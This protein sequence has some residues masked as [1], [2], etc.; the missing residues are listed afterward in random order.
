MDVVRATRPDPAGYLIDARLAEISFGDWA[1]DLSGRA[2]VRS[3]R[4]KREGKVTSCTVSSYEQLAEQSVV[5]GRSATRWSPPT[6][7]A[8]ARLRSPA[9]H[10]VTTPPTSRSSRGGLRLRRKPPDA[11]RVRSGRGAIP[12]R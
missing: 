12:S 7:H 6:A 1:P 3:R 10:S 8:G 11:V 4:A 2:R 9:S 5:R